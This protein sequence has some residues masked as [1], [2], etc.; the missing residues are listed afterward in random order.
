M[1]NVEDRCLKS[2]SCSKPMR[3]KDEDV[4]L[5]A[6]CGKEQPGTVFNKPSECEK[7]D[8]GGT[9]LVTCRNC[10]LRSLSS[11]GLRK[12]F[13]DLLCK[14]RMSHFLDTQAPDNIR[15]LSIV[16]SHSVNNGLTSDA[17]VEKLPLMQDMKEEKKNVLQ[18]CSRRG[19]T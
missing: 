1:A 4:E 14:L 5:R 17:T 7:V 12:L 10:T 9:A 13:S 6:A 19:R 15:Q 2:F 3:I 11:C 18:S 8:S 16:R